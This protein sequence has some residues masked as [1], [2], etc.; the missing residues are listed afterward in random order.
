VN[1]TAESEVAFGSTNWLGVVA[2][3]EQ[4]FRQYVMASTAFRG[5]AMEQNWGFSLEYFAPYEHVTPSHFESMLAFA[6]GAT[7]MTVY[8]MIGTRAWRGDRNLTDDD[9]PV[10]TNDRGDAS[11]GDYPGSAP[12]PSTGE[13]R[14]KFYTLQQM[15]QY[16]RSEGPRFARHGPR[17]SVAWGIYPPYA[18][19]GQ[20][21]PRGDVDDVLWRPPLRA[22]PRGS[23]HGLDSFVETMTRLGG[24]F[25]QMD[26]SREDAPLHKAH[27]L[28]LSAHEFMDG[29]TQE[30]IATY[31]EQ[32]GALLLTDV[33]PDKD[34][35]LRDLRGALATRVFPHE[36]VGFE[37]LP[38]PRPILMDGERVG[39]A[40][41]F[42]VKL[43]P[44]ADAER[45]LEVDGACAGYARRVGQGIALYLGAGP[46]R[47]RF[48]GDDRSI[49]EEDQRL[50]ER[51]LRLIGGD[52]LFPA[53]PLSGA[54]E[55]VVW[56]HGDASKDEQQI[57]VIVREHVGDVTVEFTRPG[58]RRARA[59]LSSPSQAV[60]AFAV[61]RG[62]LGACYLRGLNDTRGEFLAPRLTVGD[63]TW[64]AETPCDL[65]V[66]P[67]RQDA[68]LVSVAHTGSGRGARVHLGASGVHEVPDLRRGA[69]KRVTSRAAAAGEGR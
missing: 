66:T 33:L 56:Q 55:V 14:D 69:P 44:P 11:S 7:G 6:C 1:L 45:M 46:W 41:D 47:A 60:H 21:L 12:V 25:L 17:A 28:C 8:T 52:E 23:Y 51:L 36:E 22:V 37:K 57:F 15:T 31:V 32:G 67:D 9:A 29:A 24:G 3:D 42:V 50:I 63:E 4:A 48:S 5:P 18:W 39:R 68:L 61:R 30:R 10:R 34:D 53:R 38:F 26:V 40:V 16:F 27:A 59:T 43:R 19:G 13:R 49:A 54:G 62:Q 65:C 20:W 2:G 35:L 58:P 64:R